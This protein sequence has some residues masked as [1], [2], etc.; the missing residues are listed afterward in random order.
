MVTDVSQRLL[1]H[2][3]GLRGIFR[4]DVAELAR[5][6]GLVDAKVVRAKAVVELRRRLA[7]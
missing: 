1:A 4:L 6:R 3:G 2:H 7:V 5:L